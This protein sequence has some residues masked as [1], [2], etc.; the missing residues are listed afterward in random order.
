MPPT[1]LNPGWL[2]DN[3]F[4]LS[5]IDIDMWKA[6]VAT[7]LGYRWRMLGVQGSSDPFAKAVGVLEPISQD[8]ANR[9]MEAYVDVLRNKPSDASRQDAWRVDLRSK[10]PLST[11]VNGCSLHW[12]SVGAPWNTGYIE[13]V[14]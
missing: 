10:S 12:E 7:T 8:K 3:I 6:R 11:E 2:V 5:R 9:A 14:G 1:W 4:K 13:R